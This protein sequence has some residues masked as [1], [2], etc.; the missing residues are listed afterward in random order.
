[1]RGKSKACLSFIKRWKK[2]DIIESILCLIGFILVMQLCYYMYIF[3]KELGMFDNVKDD[4]Y[5][6]VEK[7]KELL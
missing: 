1:M 5:W 4:F 6:Y 3:M 2:E 7:I